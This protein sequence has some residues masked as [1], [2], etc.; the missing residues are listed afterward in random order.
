MLPQ[1]DPIAAQKAVCAALADLDARDSPN[2]GRLRALLALDQRAQT[3]RRCIAR[4]FRRRK[5]ISPPRSGCK[6]WQAAFELCW[7][8]GRAHGQ[9]LRS[10][11]DS[12]GFRGC[13]EYLP[14]LVLRVFQHRQIELLLRPFVDERSTRFSW[15]ELHEAY[16]FAQSR[17]LVAPQR[18]DQPLSFS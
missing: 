11:R 17:G 10:T 12:L 16:R 4:R 6:S 5:S 13:R 2:I 8:F 18:S 9:F 7:S 14:Y 3:H 1:N 15:K